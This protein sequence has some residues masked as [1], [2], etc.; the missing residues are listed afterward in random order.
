MPSVF[1]FFGKKPNA[2]S[3]NFV[4]FTCFS[5]RCHDV[6]L[7]TTNK[8]ELGTTIYFIGESI[9]LEDA[10]SAQI[11]QSGVRLYMTMLL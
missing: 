7:V 4:S 3:E 6:F 5:F 8:P 1:A 11:N 10:W 2:S 9:L